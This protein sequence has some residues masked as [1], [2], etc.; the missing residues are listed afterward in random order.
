MTEHQDP[1]VAASRRAFEYWDKPGEMPDDPLAGTPF[2][3]FALWVLLAV[4]LLEFFFTL[5]D[6]SRK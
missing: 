5:K 3:Q 2:W 1:Y 4:P 6:R